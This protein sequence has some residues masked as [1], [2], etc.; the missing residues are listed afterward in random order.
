ML[1]RVAHALRSDF[2][3]RVICILDRGPLADSLEDAGIPV[4]AM[5][6]SS[7][8][9][10]P[11][12]IASLAH[13]LAASRPDLVQTWL[14]Q[15]DLLGGLAGK[16]AGAPHVVWN[17]RAADL[18]V[19][20]SRLLTRVVVK[21]CAM[22]SPWLPSRIVCCAES[23]AR[24]HV[25]LGYDR[26]RMVTI[27]NGV[28]LD[29]FVIDAASRQSVRFELGLPPDAILIGCIAR[30]HAQKD[31][32]TLLAAFDLLRRVRPE[33]HLLLVGAGTQ[34][35]SGRMAEL[36]T[37]TVSARAIHCLGPRI[38]IPRLTAAIDLAAS[39]SAWGEAFPNVL[40]EALSCGVP[41]V[42]T[43]VGDARLIVGGHGGI[44]SSRNPQAFATSMLDVLAR[45]RNE[46]AAREH[47]QR[48]YSMARSIQGYRKLY[49]ALL[50][51]SCAE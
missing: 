4:E 24:F 5:G 33:C 34:G 42:A 35:G 39:S 41:A 36:L 15:S 32:R 13:R 27:P 48:N 21:T 8:R 47:I 30:V 11:I 12:A 20:E 14:Y 9:P 18:S 19:T 45:P 10:N 29:R 38:D 2:D 17:L 3:Q 51:E 50:T 6:V 1:V 44:V 40:A 23:A 37:G 49:N 7:R 16:I 22:L 46:E 31:H 43:D 26:R 28:D 25:S